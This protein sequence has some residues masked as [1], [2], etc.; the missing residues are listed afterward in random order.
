MVDAA[1]DDEDNSTDVAGVLD[2]ILVLLVLLLL[3]LLVLVLILLLLL[4]LF[5]LFPVADVVVDVKMFSRLGGALLRFAVVRLVFTFDTE[6][7][8]VDADVLLELLP[9][10]VVLPLLAVLLR[11]FENKRKQLLL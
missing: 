10:L 9:K 6:A 3:V 8:V 4:L 1:V 2:P 7:L 5:V 11:S